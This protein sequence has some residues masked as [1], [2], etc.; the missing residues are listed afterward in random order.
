MKLAGW[1][2]VFAMLYDHYLANAE[3]LLLVSQIACV[4]FV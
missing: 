1:F 3:G 4:L 2:L